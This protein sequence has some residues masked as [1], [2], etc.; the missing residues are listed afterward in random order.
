MEFIFVRILPFENGHWLTTH[1]TI[2]RAT[3]TNDHDHCQAR[4]SSQLRE[5]DGIH[6]A[7]ANS[8]RLSVG[9]L[10][11]DMSELG[12]VLEAASAMWKAL[13]SSVR[14]DYVWSCK[15]SVRDTSTSECWGQ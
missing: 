10:G 14:I 11:T 1:I 2:P 8:A 9:V 3:T 15:V 4:K 6:D 12:A 5:M 7:A 13:P